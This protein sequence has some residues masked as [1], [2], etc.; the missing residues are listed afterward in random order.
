[1]LGEAEDQLKLV[2]AQ[3]DRIWSPQDMVPPVEGVAGGGTAYGWG[4]GSSQDQSLLRGTI[5]P[6]RIPSSELVNVWCMPSTANVGPQETPRPLE[7]IIE[8]SNSN[9]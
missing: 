5:D 1:M 9:G 2:T 4:D 8:L 6:T 7:P 3:F